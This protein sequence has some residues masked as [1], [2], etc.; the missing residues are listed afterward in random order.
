M[1]ETFAISLNG[2]TDLPAGK[3]AAIVT[4]LE[5]LS[6]P[7]RRVDPPGVEEVR[8]GGPA[9]VNVLPPDDALIG[10]YSMDVWPAR[11]VSTPGRAVYGASVKKRAR[12]VI[13]ASPTLDCRTRPVEPYWNAPLR[14][15]M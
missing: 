2:T 6:A 10:P 15:V 4:S 1:S 13:R 5:M 11:S 14:K 3:I 8:F 7:T 9:T 12:A